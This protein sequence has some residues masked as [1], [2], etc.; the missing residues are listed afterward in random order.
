MNIGTSVAFLMAL[1][2]IGY[3]AVSCSEGK[4]ITSGRQIFSKIVFP[5][6]V[7]IGIGYAAVSF[8]Q[9]VETGRLETRERVLSISGWLDNC[10]PFESLDGTRSLDFKISDNT[11]KM[12]MATDEESAAGALS[13]KHPKVAN[14]TWSADQATKQVVLSFDNVKSHYLLVVAFSQDQCILSAGDVSSADL[15]NSWFGTPYSKPEASD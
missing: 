14:G 9:W 5:M 15:P 11:A 4:L 7:L 6:T 3:G 10:S 13:A 2:V 8:S 12:T 1:Y